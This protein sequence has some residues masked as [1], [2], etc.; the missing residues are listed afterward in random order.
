MAPTKLPK[1]KQKRQEQKK[2]E[3]LSP[4]YHQIL[5]N[6]SILPDTAAIP[7]PV[8]ALHEGVSRRTIKRSYPLVKI[9]DHREGVL[10]GYLRRKREVVAA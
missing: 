10:L 8:A 3:Q 9:S 1:Q 7:L 2:V 4:L 6:I 5:K